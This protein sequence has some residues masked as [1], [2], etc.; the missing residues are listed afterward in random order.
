MATMT[1]AQALASSAT[2]IIVADTPAN[3]AAAL[4]NA[5]LVARVTHFS[6][7]ANGSSTAATAKVIATLGNKF[8]PGTFQYTVRDSVAALSNPAN[9]AGVA[10]A[11]A[12]AVYDTAANLLAAATSSLVQ[13]AAS[14]LM[15]NSAA[16]SLANLLRLE[17]LPAFSVLPGQG[18]TLADSAANLLALT[19]AQNRPS[20]KSFQVT[21]NSTVS[22]A[23]AVTLFAF[24]GFSVASGATLFI[25]DTA[26]SMTTVGALAALPHMATVRGVAVNVSDTIGNLLPVAGTLASLAQSVSSLGVT[27][28]TDATV[29]V[30]QINTL[31]PLFGRFFVLAGHALTLA[32]TLQNL[33]TVT[34]N[35]ISLA[36]I[37]VLSQSAN[38]T[39]AQLA[40]LTAMHQFSVGVGAHLTV[41]GTL[42]QLNAVSPG[43][44][45]VVAAIVAQDTVTHLTAAS[46][47]PVGT[48]AILALMDGAQYTAA[49]AAQIGDLATGGRTLTL[50]P[51]GSF[52]SMTIADTLENLADFATQIS[53]LVGHGPVTLS[54][55]DANV[56]LSAASVM[57]LIGLDAIDISAFAVSVSDGGAAITAAANQLFGFGLKSIIVVD[58]V[59]AGT[60]P[61]RML[62]FSCF[63]RRSR[64]WGAMRPSAQ[65]NS[66]RCPCCP[67]FLSLPVLLSRCRT[68]RS[69]LPPTPP[70]SA[71]LPLQ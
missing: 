61:A 32:D 18:I 59:F 16:L 11:S 10:I 38:A 69:A 49:Q 37:T 44:L 48:T 25:S 56:T 46:G 24:P 27:M 43:Q 1:I 68:T 34:P 29:S 12:I 70:S 66:Y 19:A 28:I 54:P 50:V 36:Q 21:V 8:S 15:S 7:S 14:T 35:A 57:A 62:G 67:G 20:I 55:T 51:N 2:G 60:V 53:A 22:E 26:S 45:S 17:A 23:N 64:N 52:T 13:H 63:R 41:T 30:A 6:L 40:T 31:V 4:P 33:L 9:A 65:P 71:H 5:G 42:A 58:G 39:T 3:I 47:M